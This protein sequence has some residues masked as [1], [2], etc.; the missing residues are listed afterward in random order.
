MKAQQKRW[1]ST[2]VMSKNKKSQKRNDW[3]ERMFGNM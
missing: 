2:G 1:N 3:N